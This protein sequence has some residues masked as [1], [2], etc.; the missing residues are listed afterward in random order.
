MAIISS[1]RDFKKVFL[2]LLTLFPFAT[3]LAQVT[4][5]E[6]VIIK[7]N[8]L[9]TN[10][11]ENGTQRALIAQLSGNIETNDPNNKPY[12]VRLQKTDQYCPFD[13]DE[14][15]SLQASSPALGGITKVTASYYSTPTGGAVILH[16]FLTGCISEVLTEPFPLINE[17]HSASMFKYITLETDYNWFASSNIVEHGNTNKLNI[18]PT[19]T[20]CS[21]T[22]W[23]QVYDDINISVTEG[24]QYGGLK[25]GTN[26]PEQTVTVKCA[27]V[28]DLS[29]AASGIQPV[30]GPA[31]A[32]VE[33]RIDAAGLVHE[34][35]F[36]VNC[37][38]EPVRQGQKS[39][40]GIPETWAGD[41]YAYKILENDQPG[42][43]GSYG[44]ATSCIAIVLTTFGYPWTPGR[45]NAEMKGRKPNEGGYD[46][47]TNNTNWD[48][49]G[50]LTENKIS[51]TRYGTN[52][53]NASYTNFTPPEVLN[54]SL[55]DNCK[56]VIVQVNNNGHTH[57][58]VVKAKT[59]DGQS[60]I[61][62]DPGLGKTRL[63]EYGNGH[64]I[65]WS[66]CIVSSGK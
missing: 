5:K 34:T 24:G 63:D 53:P 35:S 19:Q 9:R 14:S 47:L 38:L 12:R 54:G 46:P 15:P 8:T 64:N 32:K 2:L 18:E 21:S 65:F 6:K 22:V 26:N 51:I 10:S 61:I 57:W 49:A 50:F 40:N 28:A 37:K 55:I 33:A 58:V 16:A 30:G 56:L 39:T 43:F 4:I 42:L 13:Y 29:F 48:I 45:L 31:Q 25:L 36:L 60:Y 44:C 20:V 17:Y 11:S 27:N 41:Q 3:L 1:L 52:E 66:Y 7:P 59:A 23:H 62:I